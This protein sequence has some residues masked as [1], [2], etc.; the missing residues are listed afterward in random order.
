[1]KA[2]QEHL[3]AH[4]IV[5]G[6]VQGVWFRASTKEEADRIGVHGWV[7]NLPDNRVEIFAEGD[8]ESLERFARQIARGPGHARVEAVETFDEDPTGRSGAFLIRY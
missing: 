3:R 1:M 4:V 7:R 8:G 6:R 2:N 5:Q